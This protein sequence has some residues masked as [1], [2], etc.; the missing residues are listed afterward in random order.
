M[1]RSREGRYRISPTATRASYPTK[2][3][4]GALGRSRRAMPSRRRRSRPGIEPR[5][6]SHRMQERRESAADVT[7]TPQVA[8]SS[9]DAGTLP[10]A[11]SVSHTERGEDRCRESGNVG[12]KPRRSRNFVARH[13]GVPARRG[14]LATAVTPS[15]QVDAPASLAPVASELLLYAAASVCRATAL[16]ERRVLRMRSSFS[17]RPRCCV[18]RIDQRGLVWTDA[19]PVAGAALAHVD[20]HPAPG[21]G[22]SDR[23]LLLGRDG[24]SR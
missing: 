9:R 10:I 14:L 13:A 23:T 16:Y 19:L 4:R 24:L 7:S 22:D 12:N 2:R 1:A 11:T 18:V 5:Q 21:M 20:R 15:P 3:S 6:R 8:R 17:C